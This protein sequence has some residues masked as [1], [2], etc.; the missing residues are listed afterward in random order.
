MNK[1]FFPA[2]QRGT[3]NSGWLRSNFNFSFSN[4]YNPTLA[5][6][7]TLMAFND[8]FLQVGKGFGVHPH[9]NMEIISIL[10][11][12][13][14]NHKDSMGYNTTIQAGGVQIMS[15]G[16]GLFHEEY[17]VGEV[18]VNFLQIWIQPKLQNIKPR[19]QQRLFPKQER[20]NQLTTVVSS[21]EGFEH[22][23]INQNAKISLG[24]FEKATHFEYNFNKTNKCVFIFCIEGSFHIANQTL[25]SR[26]A[27]GIWDT[28]QIEIQ[29]SANSELI[30][31][32]TVI[33]Q[34]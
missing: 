31:I 1:I 10:L 27:I 6:F 21:E 19:Y 23:W 11:H 33:N 29:A 28:A 13:E 26:D 17:N 16:Q 25:V 18:E 24:Y 14:M 2:N 3:K 30:I 15:A 20:V 9:Q 7:G 5:A 12:G 4:Y 32:E 34:K 22:C 8:D